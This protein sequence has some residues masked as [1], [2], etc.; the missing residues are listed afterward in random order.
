MR[1]PKRAMPASRP[2]LIGVLACSALLFASSLVR[3]AY[4][5]RHFHNASFPYENIFRILDLVLFGLIAATVLGRHLAIMRTVKREG[6]SRGPL[7]D[8]REQFSW[9]KAYRPAFFVLLATQ[10]L[11]K[12]LAIVWRNPYE[13]PHQPEFALG[14]AV[15]VLV[16]TFLY[17]DREARDE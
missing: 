4:F 6:F 2:A 15:M 3:I 16:G 1:E 10:L 13:I 7:Q 8:E 12:F 9:L 5:I 11:G 17:H 14:A